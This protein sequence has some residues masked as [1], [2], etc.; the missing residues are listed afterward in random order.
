MKPEFIISQNIL[1]GR[2][3]LLNKGEIH[4]DHHE[5]KKMSKYF[6]YRAKNWHV[7][8]HWKVYD[9]NTREVAHKV[10]TDNK[11]RSAGLAFEPEDEC[12]AH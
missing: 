1:T 9:K 3:Q 12:P 10:H 4:I 7:E 2:R 11:T 8:Y 6:W 5:N